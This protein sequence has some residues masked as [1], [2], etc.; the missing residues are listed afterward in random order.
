MNKSIHTCAVGWGIGGNKMRE[1]GL[2]VGEVY[3]IYTKSIARYKIFNTAHD[4]E[5]MRL[6]LCLCRREGRRQR[7]SWLIKAGSSRIQEAIEEE[8]VGPRKVQLIAYCIM[9]T[10]IHL[11]LRQIV[12]NGISTYMNCV[13]NSYTRFFNTKYNRKGPLWESRFQ[14]RHIATSEDVLHLTRYIHLNPVTASLATKPG[15]W[16][17]SS[18]DEYFSVEANKK[19]ICEFRDLIDLSQN[20]YKK[21]VTDRR[22]YRRDLGRFREDSLGVDDSA[23]P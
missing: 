18:Y 23:V 7:L 6:L 5:R 10:H 20:Q 4:F 17:Y 13:L 14:D 22:G 8:R 2:A 9:Q 3:P 19:G 16:R 15:D 11:L 21:F 12:F 1:P